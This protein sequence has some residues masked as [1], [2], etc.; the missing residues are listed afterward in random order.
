[1]KKMWI[2]F[3]SCLLAIPIALLVWGFLLPQQYGDTFLGE[4][5][6]KRQLLEQ[7][8]EK[9]RLVILGGS[10]A[11]FGVDSALLAQQ[12]PQYQPVNFGLYAALGTRIMLDLSL[13]SLREGDLVIVMPEQ[14]SQTLSDYLGAQAVWQ[15]AD[16]DFSVLQ[17]L[18][19]RDVSAMIGQFPRFAAQKFRYWL[20]GKPEMTGVYQRSSFN[21]FGDV[22]SELCAANQMPGGVDETTPIRFDPEL[23]EEGFCQQL[24]EYAAVLAQKGVTVWY[25]FP[26]MNESAVEL[27][28]EVDGY[29]DVLQQ[30]LEISLA[31][32]PKACILESGWFYDTNFHLNA[33]GKTV[34]TRQLIRDIK[35]MLGDSTPTRIAQPAMPELLA[36]ASEEHQLDNADADC[37]VWEQTYGGLQLIGLTEEGSCRTELTVPG[38]IQ[39]KPVVALADTVFEQ[40]KVLQCVTIQSNIKALPDGLFAGCLALRQ[41]CLT[42]TDPAQLAVGQELLRQAATDCRL[43]V[44]ADSYDRYCLNYSWSPYATFLQRGMNE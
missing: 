44:P 38:Q 16:G 9:P 7:E 21:A 15:A 22:V 26:P 10:A 32:D 31:G 13:E 40:S 19:W 27:D 41:I 11:A 24:N 4:L 3:G 8:S 12:L 34:F 23:L 42:Q 25:H 37:F 14:Q 5:S 33:S 17:A 18:H 35:A 29:A 36:P 30:R 6:V 2:C 20:T 1:M 43:V 28:A 39:G